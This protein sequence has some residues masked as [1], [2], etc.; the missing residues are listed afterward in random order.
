MSDPKEMPFLEHLKELRTRLIRILAGL[1]VGAIIAFYFSELLFA[2]LTEPI[3]SNFKNLQIIGTGVA[4][5]FSM[6]LRIAIAAGIVLSLPWSF[7]EIWKFISPGL[8]EKERKLAAPFIFI[9]SILFISGIAFCFYLVLPTA[10]S[11][12]SDEFISIGLAPQI[13]ISEYLSFVTTFMLV[14]GIVFEVPVLTFALARAKMV[15]H[16]QLIKWFRLSIVIIFILAGVLTPTPDIMSQLLLAIP[17]LILYG[18]CIGVA[19]Y[20]NRE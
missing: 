8:L 1:L 9:S 4:E 7:S 3:R 16:Q 15:T 18:V 2:F 11:F 5:A 19:Y 13:R 17:M 10:L 12:F 6:K 20:V 14:F